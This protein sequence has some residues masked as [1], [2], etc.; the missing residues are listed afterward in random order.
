MDDLTDIR[1]HQRLNQ[2]AKALGVLGEA[3]GLYQ[4]R[5]LTRIEKQGA[6]KAFE[7]THELAWNVMKDFFAWQGNA[8]IMGS[9]DATRE[10]FTKGL[11]EDGAAWMQM[12][13][14]R[15]QTAHT[16]NEQ[17]ADDILADVVNV[18]YPLFIAFEARMRELADAP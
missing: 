2:Y 3:V 9:R 5:A 4:Q 18:Y 8:T 6:I 16:Y 10:A 7:F 12:I 15:N 17:T 13:P 1:W 11:I 14:S